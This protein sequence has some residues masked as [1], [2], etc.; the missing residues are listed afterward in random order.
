[1]RPSTLLG[2]LSRRQPRMYVYMQIHT[3]KMRA[4]CTCA[5]SRKRCSLADP[6]WMD[7]LPTSDL[8]GLDFSRGLTYAMH[9]CALLVFRFH[10][11]LFHRT[12]SCRKFAAETQVTRVA[13][14]GIY[15]ETHHL[16]SVLGIVAC[17]GSLCSVSKHLIYTQIRRSWP[18]GGECPMLIRA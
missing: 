16:Y 18:G 15:V 8:G 10:V 12:L 3:Y 7:R 1:M 14:S 6:A 13:V 5:C 2:P 11:S 17:L 4:P 9:L